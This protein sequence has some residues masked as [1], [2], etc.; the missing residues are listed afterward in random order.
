MTITY[1][2]ITFQAVDINPRVFTPLMRLIFKL[3]RPLVQV[4]LHSHHAFLPGNRCSCLCDPATEELLDC[5]M[6]SKQA[7]CQCWF[8]ACSQTSWSWTWPLQPCLLMHLE[9]QIMLIP[10]LF[11]S[12]LPVLSLSL[13]S[14]NSCCICIC[15]LWCW[16]SF[17]ITAFE[18]EGSSSSALPLMMPGMSS[19]SRQSTSCSLQNWCQ[20]V[21][22]R[23]VPKI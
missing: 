3:F 9:L 18:K 16:F 1:T 11:I 8:L 13:S 22:N 20:Y 4:H 21:Q 10:L 6:A 19:W 5:F 12:C 15:S 2:C 23:S 14:P 7:D 17:V